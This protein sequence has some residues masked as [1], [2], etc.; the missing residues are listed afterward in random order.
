MQ[1]SAK[2]RALVGLLF[3]AAGLMLLLRLAGIDLRIFPFSLPVYVFSWQMILIILGIFFM[4][5]EGNRQT[6]LFLF[7]IGAVFLARE[8]FN[9][10]FMDIARFAIPVFLVMAGIIL[11]FPGRLSRKR[12]KNDEHI[13]KDA[14]DSLNIVNIFSGG[15]RLIQSNPFR[16]GE[17]VCIFG[18]ADLNFREAS[19]ADEGGILHVTC[20]FGGC[21]LYIPED[22][23][24]RT[25]ATTLFAG[26]SDKRISSSAG[27]NTDPG[28]VIVI[29]G[30]LL[31][32]G[33]DIKRV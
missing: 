1:K 13:S 23:T 29:R 28:K 27:L 19:L 21:E 11:L 12:Q 31:F 18:G 8:I 25:E 6:G 16:G 5:T 14:N 7:A 3:I 20:I 10:T 32:S 33:L 4:A 26:V 17:V 30:T 22:W 24:I 15:T 9:A 2:V